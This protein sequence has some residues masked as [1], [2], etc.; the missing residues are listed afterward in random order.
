MPPA[1]D[2]DSSSPEGSA[3]SYRVTV[4][5][6]GDIPGHLDLTFQLS[7]D[8]SHGLELPADLPAKPL[9]RLRLVL[10]RFRLSAYLASN[11]L[12]GGSLLL[13]PVEEAGRKSSRL[14]PFADGGEARAEAR[15]HLVVH[16]D[17]GAAS[18]PSSTNN[19]T[20]DERHGNQGRRGRTS[21]RVG[22]PSDGLNKR[23]RPK[24]PAG[25]S[26]ASSTRDHR[27]A[28]AGRRTRSTRTRPPAA[29]AKRPS[30]TPSSRTYA[31][32]GAPHT[33]PNSAHR[34]QGHRG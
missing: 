15:A 34:S 27:T 13:D 32:P 21:K 14:H 4:E 7:A 30:C 6:A 12:E 17:R 16:D 33:A 20:P 11:L 5:R 19:R 25:S 23:G 1:T 31:L 3:Q 28:R 2:G 26:C 8:L 9:E 18:R 24:A 29:P 22:R 10:Y